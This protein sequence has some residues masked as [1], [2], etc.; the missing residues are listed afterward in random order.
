VNY[1]GKSE[2]GDGRM[3][4]YEKLVERC[5]AAALAAPRIR[6]GV[7]RKTPAIIAEVMHTLENVTKEQSEKGEDKI[8]ESIRSEVK[9]GVRCGCPDC[10][11][12]AWVSVNECYLAMLRASPGYP[13]KGESDV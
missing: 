8:A 7:D 5:R 13:P 12:A 1:V 10:D 9:F 6:D 2:I 3:S 4:T 11:K